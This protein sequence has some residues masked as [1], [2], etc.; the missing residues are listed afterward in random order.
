MDRAELR[1]GR[2][3]TIDKRFEQLERSNR[4][5]RALTITLCLVMGA[6][7]LMA[8]A[9]PGAVPGVI[10]VQ[11]L[12]IVT[13]QGVPVVVLESAGDRGGR[14]L[15][16]N[17]DGNI[18]FETVAGETS[19]SNGQGQKLVR[20]AATK[21]GQ[22]MV[23]TYNLN[24]EG[25]VAVGSTKDGKGAITTYNGQGQKLITLSAMENGGAVS[26]WNNQGQ[27]ISTIRAGDDGKGEVGAWDHD[28]K[29][30]RLTPD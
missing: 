30:R 12:E 8:Q 1:K 22:G 17:K 24:G 6:G 7:L 5:W 25:V 3:M 23:T 26:V 16:A 13:K 18:H 10:Q 21:D 28:G 2:T 29:G 20:L 14:I 27:A 15:T 4:R 11:R 9:G 19:V